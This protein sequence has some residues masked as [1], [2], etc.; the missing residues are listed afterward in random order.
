MIRGRFSVLIEIHRPEVL[1]RLGEPLFKLDG[2]CPIEEPFCACR[3]G[4]TL[5]RVVFREIVVDD[6]RFGTSHRDGHF[7]ELLDCEL[8]LVPKVHWEMD[9]LSVSVHESHETVDKIVPIAK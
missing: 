3:V 7:G 4:L 6:R 2:W 5:H 9:T 1:D 8:T